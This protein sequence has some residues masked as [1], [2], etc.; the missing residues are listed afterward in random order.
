LL[1]V[2]LGAAVMATPA[3]AACI[4]ESSASLDQ[5]IILAQ[6]GGGGGGGGAGGSSDSSQQGG[7]LN[8]ATPG[9]PGS[10]IL[11]STPQEMTG[12]SLQPAQ[13]AAVPLAPEQGRGAPDPS[14]V[15]RKPREAPG[16]TG[17]MP[18]DAPQRR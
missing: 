16:G 17:V 3:F 12:R 7:S 15:D 8:S 13:G 6:A 18:G 2:A 5:P 9:S 14:A 11:G 4:E 10:G 1:A